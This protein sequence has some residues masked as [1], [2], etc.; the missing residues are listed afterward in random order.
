M[1]AISHHTDERAGFI[2]KPND[3]RGDWESGGLHI[4]TGYGDG[5]LNYEKTSFGRN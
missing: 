3:P 2:V 4:A 5:W 1:V